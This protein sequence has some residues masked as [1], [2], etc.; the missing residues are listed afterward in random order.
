VDVSIENVQWDATL[1]IKSDVTTYQ[2]QYSTLAASFSTDS[3]ETISSSDGDMTC[4]DFNPGY[5]STFRSDIKVK[6]SK[7]HGTQTN[8]CT[9]VQIIK[10]FQKVSCAFAVSMAT[11]MMCHK[12]TTVSI[13]NEIERHYCHYRLIMDIDT[14]AMGDETVIDNM[15]NLEE[16]KRVSQLGIKLHDLLLVSLFS[17]QDRCANY[18]AEISCSAFTGA[19]MLASDANMLTE[20]V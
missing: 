16:L 7:L 10:P 2:K 12:Q 18:T 20:Y 3:F 6:W 11:D 14:D 19:D 4:Y 13:D 15:L 1:Q 9:I 5:T 17:F 8:V